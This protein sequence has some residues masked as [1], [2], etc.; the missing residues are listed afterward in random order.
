M[1]HLKILRNFIRR[2]DGTVA[3]IFAVTAVP[4]TFLTGMGVDYTMAVDRQVQLNAAADAAVLAAITPAMMAQ[5]PTVAAQAATDTFNAQASTV[6]GA[7]YASSDVKVTVD[8]VGA[9][10]VVT[11]RYAAQ[12][13]NLFAGVLGM[14]SLHLSGGSQGTGGQAPNIDFYL[15]L[16]DSPSMAIAATQAGINTMVSNTSKQGGCAFGCH[17]SHPSSDNL[18]N[19]NG[20]DNYALAQSLSVPLRMDL[21]RQASQNLM[22]TAQTTE[23]TTTASYRMAIYTFDQGFNTIASL[24]SNLAT[25]KTQ[26]GNIQLQQVYANNWLTSAKNNNDTDTNYD[27]AMTSINGVMPN[28]GSGTAVAGDQPQEVLFFVTDGVEDESS[29]G[30][31]VQSLMD[32]GW[33]TKIKA[34]GIRIAVLYTEYLPLPTNAWYNQYISPFQSNIG[35]KVQTGGD[36]SAALANLF[37]YAVQS[38]YLS[39]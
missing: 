17:E 29:G 36:I 30:A 22:T 14:Q 23:A 5:T 9:K 35:S 21:V 2:R 24:T 12:S 33:C 27:N 32:P 31:R 20:E 4:I 25:A 38:A 34:R 28:P 13:Q 7:A 15:L 39:Q 18:G 26:A 37:Q 1:G 8:T 19:P 3:M 11:L 6:S 16:D 10:R